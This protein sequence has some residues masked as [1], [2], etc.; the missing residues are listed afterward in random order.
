M[1]LVFGE[2]MDKTKY[3]WQHVCSVKTLITL[4]VYYVR[5]RYIKFLP[6]LVNMLPLECIHDWSST[7]S[8]MIDRANSACEHKQNN[9]SLSHACHAC[10]TG[11]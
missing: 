4:A 5:L 6:L 1:R 10:S 9:M 3:G 7:N 8:Y 2:N 11:R